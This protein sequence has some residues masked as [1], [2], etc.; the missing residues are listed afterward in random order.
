MFQSKD[1]K[2]FG[3]AYVAKRR[4]SEH[5]KAMQ[6]MGEGP[7]HEAKESP[8]FESGEQE[9]AQEGAEPQEPTQ[10]VAKHGRATSVNITHD[11][12][13]KKHHVTSTHE[14]GHVHQSDHASAAEAHNHATAL[15]GSD[16]APAE[17]QEPAE[18]APEADGF[19]MPRL[20]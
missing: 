10:I 1:G 11:H 15:A 17:G 5:D 9:G 14:R 3:S 6:A 19:K 8:E 16:Q 12:K 4:D 18:E 20:A 13:N 2:K 7:E